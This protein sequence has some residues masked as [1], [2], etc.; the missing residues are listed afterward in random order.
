MFKR[1]GA[2]NLIVTESQSLTVCVGQSGAPQ[3][4][5]M[6]DY[7]SALLHMLCWRGLQ[8]LPGACRLHVTHRPSS[9]Y[10]VCNS[11]GVETVCTLQG[12][13]KSVPAAGHTC[14]ATQ[15]DAAL[16]QAVEAFFVEAAKL[17][18]KYVAQVVVAVALPLSG[19]HDTRLGVGLVECYAT[20]HL[21]HAQISWRCL[22]SM[23]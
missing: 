8:R 5:L 2:L 16:Q 7:R 22:Q 3:C 19:Q 6:H 14:M 13:R 12:H 18:R 15:Q 23:Q 4:P 11:V 20:E 10:P 1:P 21:Q 17:R 9:K